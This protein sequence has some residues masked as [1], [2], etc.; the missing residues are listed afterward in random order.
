MQAM[1]RLK[2]GDAVLA[3]DRRLRRSPAA[4]MAAE[5]ML[6]LAREC[7][8]ASRKDRSSMKKCAEV[9]W[10]IGIDFREMRLL[11]SSSSSAAHVRSE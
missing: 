8:A 6:K 5:G 10:R 2:E 11:S 9:L 1:G 7:V 3:M 4:I